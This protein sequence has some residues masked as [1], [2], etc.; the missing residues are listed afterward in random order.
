MERGWIPT[1]DEFG[2]VHMVLDALE[3]HDIARAA[4]L[5][6][7]LALTEIVIILGALTP[8]KVV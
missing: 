7:D 2:R 1:T 6:N 8:D 5:V 4:R 3:A